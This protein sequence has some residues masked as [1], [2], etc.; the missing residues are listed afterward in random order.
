MTHD[1]LVTAA[2]SWLVRYH[3]CPVVA[4]EL[5][6]GAGETP[7]VIGWTSGGA[8]ILIECKA[9]RADFTRDKHKYFRRTP[10]AGMGRTRYFCAP[11]GLLKPEEMPPGWGLVQV[12]VKTLTVAKESECPCPDAEC[13]HSGAFETRAHENEAVVLMSLIRRLAGPGVRGKARVHI[14]AYTLDE[15]GN[16]VVPATATR[17][18]GVA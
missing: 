10:Q 9:S 12:G 1:Q 4:A 2:F 14:R 15:R 18:V 11:A 7:D 5:V 8:T 17:P 3:R 13:W 6:T 16:T